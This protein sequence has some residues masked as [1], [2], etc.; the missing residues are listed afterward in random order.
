MH[1]EDLDQGGEEHDHEVTEERSQDVEAGTAHHRRQ[2]GEDAERGEPDDPVDDAV[3]QVVGAAQDLHQRAQAVPPD[4]VHRQAEDDGQEQDLEHIA[5]DEGPDHVPGHDP[6]EDVKR[7]TRLPGVF[8]SGETLAERLHRLR[9]GAPARPQQDREGDPD[10]EGDP[11]G[12]EVVGHR[13]GPDAAG[14]AALGADEGE[15]ERHEDERRHEH[16]QQLDEEVRHRLQRRRILVQDE[17]DD[18]PED[19]AGENL[20]VKRHRP[21]APDDGADRR[22]EVERHGAD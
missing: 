7:R 4:R 8:G 22:R 15:G 12:G 10:S 16:P 2:D 17:A 20:E 5:L 6:E 21:Q 14:G 19:R 13:T 11:Q 18:D 9:P 1:P 3:E